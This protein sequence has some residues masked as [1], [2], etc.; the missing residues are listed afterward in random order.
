MRSSIY[1]FIYLREFIYM[2]SSYDVV[3]S[4]CY[5]ASNGGI[6]TELERVWKEA[7]VAYYE[8]LSRHLPRE[9]EENDAVS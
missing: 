7:V 9:T 3:S 5:V 2:L 4:S 1:L 8:V 6:I